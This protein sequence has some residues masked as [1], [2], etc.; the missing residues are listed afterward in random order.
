VLVAVRVV[1]DGERHVSA[2]IRH[3]DVPQ[4]ADL[5]ERHRPP[6]AAPYG[7]HDAAAGA[8][9]GRIEAHAEPPTHHRVQS[10]EVRAE[11]LLE[12]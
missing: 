6:R 2:D 10:L 12:H 9:L 7:G 3:Q 4:P 5:Q 1:L 11:R 8:R